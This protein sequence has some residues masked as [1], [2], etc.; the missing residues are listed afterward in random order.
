M[1]SSN[2]S[3]LNWS[4]IKEPVSKLSKEELFIL[5]KDLFS[6]SK[7]NKSFLIARFNMDK[8]EILSF[9][10]GQIRKHLTP[11]ISSYKK[12]K[13]TP[14]KKLIQEYKNASNDLSGTLEL[15]FTAIEKCVYLMGENNYYEDP[16]YNGFNSILSDFVLILNSKSEEYLEEFRD[17]L[18]KLRIEALKIEWRYGKIIA[19]KI[20]SLLLKGAKQNDAGAA[21]LSS[22]IP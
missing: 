3:K 4:I 8:N 22:Q 13:I 18:E 17:R 20:S 9:Y 19:D 7:D 21:W 11:N 12:I 5:V 1:N 2:K 10:K 15:M 16:F 6:R 14:V